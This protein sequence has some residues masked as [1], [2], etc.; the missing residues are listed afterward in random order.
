MAMIRARMT[1]TWLAVATVLVGVAIVGLPGPASAFGLWKPGPPIYLSVSSSVTCVGEGSRCF[2]GLTAYD[3]DAYGDPFLNLDDLTLVGWPGS[4]IQVAGIYYGGLW[5]DCGSPGA[6]E[7]SVTAVDAGALA[8]DTTYP[9]VIA[10][11]YA[12]GGPLSPAEPPI[13][14]YHCDT[15]GTSTTTSAAPNQP[16]DTTYSWT[17]SGP[18]TIE[19][20][21]TGSSAQVKAANPS[22]GQCQ[23]T[24]TCTY[25][26]LGT[27][28][29]SQ[30]NVRVQKPYRLVEKEVKHVQFNEE[31]ANKG[32]T[33]LQYWPRTPTV[34]VWGWCWDICYELRDQCDEVLYVP[35]MVASES[36]SGYA[37]G[38]QDNPDLES[39]GSFCDCVGLYDTMG[40]LTVFTQF[41][42]YGTQTWS[43]WG[44]LVR[45]TYW[46]FTNTD[47]TR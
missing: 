25:S 26:L 4:L 30:V 36:W 33:C 8:D 15:G 32:D 35:G 41:G 42:D 19:G 18:L 14:Y 21:T 10:K 23:G 5:V 20:S 37:P 2:I 45:T 6:H 38:Q 40:A 24:V 34:I 16:G 29:V 7:Y 28:C 9:I 22:V 17:T 46:S 47:A 3:E 43:V 12:I 1:G 31:P 27:Q 13:L 44:C 39:D 11:A